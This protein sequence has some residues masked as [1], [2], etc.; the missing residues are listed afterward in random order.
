[1]LISISFVES[2]IKSVAKKNFGAKTV[3]FSTCNFSD[4][5]LLKT[6]I[7][8]SNPY[9]ILNLFRIKALALTILYCQD[10]CI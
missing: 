1:M 2:G 3:N 7:F 6:Q 4:A 5:I 10:C 8:S 9:T